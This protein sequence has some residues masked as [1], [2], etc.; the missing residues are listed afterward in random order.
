MQ[1]EYE[2]TFINVDK[3]EVRQRLTMAGAKLVRPE[4]LQRRIIFDLPP[5]KQDPSRW[6]RVRDEGDRITLSLKVVDG[7][8]IENQQELCLT[9]NNMDDAAELLTVIGCR[10][11]L[12]R[13]QARAL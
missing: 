6:L 9:V 7:D 10:Q 8:R 3:D 12:S 5:G 11:G 2:A 13:N 1:I 4:F